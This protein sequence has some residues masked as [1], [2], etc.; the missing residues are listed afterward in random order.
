MS[1]I[2]WFSVFNSV[3]DSEKLIYIFGRFLPRLA[4]LFSMVLHFVPKFILVFKR[5]LAAQSDFCGKNK[6]KQYIGAFSASVSVMLEGS[7]QTADSMS[8]RGYGVK[9][10]SFYCRFPFTKADTVFTVLSLGMLT[11]VLFALA[12]GQLDFLIYPHIEMCD[13]TI[14]SVIGMSAFGVL[15]FMPF[16][17]ELKEELVWKFS[18]SK[19]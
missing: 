17:I 8:A 2:L 15:S 12:T 11:T 6:F 4:L 7:V 18:L 16:I 5:T 10:R 1:V 19:I 9:K 3:F 14:L 13:I